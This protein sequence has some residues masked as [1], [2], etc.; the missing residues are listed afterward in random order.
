MTDVP[1]IATSPPGPRT[2]EILER[3]KQVL[4]RGLGCLAVALGF[5]GGG[6]TVRYPSQV[7]L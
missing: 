6:R 1:H 7:R 4:Y 2:R 5:I 3:Q